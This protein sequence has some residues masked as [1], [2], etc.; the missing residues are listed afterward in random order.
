M[1][2]AISNGERI[3]LTLCPHVARFLMCQP[4]MLSDLAAI[5][6]ELYNQ[7]EN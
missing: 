5:D 6:I 2:L 4:P 1:G 3:P 7:L